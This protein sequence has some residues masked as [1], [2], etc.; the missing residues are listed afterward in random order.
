MISR[1]FIFYF[2]IFSFIQGLLQDIGE[3][4]ASK[5]DN[6]E[7][8][9]QDTASSSSKVIVSN[10]KREWKPSAERLLAQA[11]SSQ[12]VTP[13]QGRQ[14]SRRDRQDSFTSPKS[15]DW[16]DERSTY[17]AYG[18]DTQS[19]RSSSP[20]L[21][22]AQAKADR[23]D[24]E[25]ILN[26]LLMT[27]DTESS[28]GVGG[29]S[30]AGDVDYFDFSVESD[31]LAS[32]S[33][34]A[35]KQ[36]SSKS[37]KSSS[38]A[39]D[40]SMRNVAPKMEDFASFEQYLDALV[41]HERTALN[42]ASYMDTNTQSKRSSSKDSDNSGGNMNTRDLDALDDSLVAFLGGEDDDSMGRGART[43]RSQQSTPSRAGDSY[44]GG[45]KAESVR[46][47]N[48]KAASPVSELKAETE[49]YD[50]LNSFLDSLE[51]SNV[52][53]SKGK[54]I[55]VSQKESTA[56]PSKAAARVAP[57]VAAPVAVQSPS[58]A[59]IVVVAPADGGYSSLTLKDLKEK[60]RERGLPVSG[61]KAELVSRL[62]A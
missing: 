59:A 46:S 22:D 58:P 43:P 30:S 56:T 33:S 10:G 34:A 42:G 1:S 47:W 14:D 15:N 27:L 18:S 38:K 50:D 2:D 44:E 23:R 55:K 53:P 24:S 11:Q 4:D 21:G 29:L 37:S 57:K 25:R 32:S 51:A 16:F 54:E 5:N 39:S 26:E 60:L 35:R 31:E 49:N 48:P 28:G 52:L 45:S 41:S 3:P 20:P 12:N 8:A 36:S 19:S 40:S 7:D 9:A 6:G 13:P 61:N 62:S 17:D